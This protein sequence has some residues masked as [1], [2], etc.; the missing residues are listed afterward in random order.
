METNTNL[1]EDT[2]VQE[3]QLPKVES[4][5]KFSRSHIIL[6]LIVGIMLVINIT[7]LAA[8]YSRITSFEQSVNQNLNS[9]TEKV[10]DFEQTLNL[11]KS[12][13]DDNFHR[14]DLLRFDEYVSGGVVT[15]QL[16]VEKAQ[17]LSNDIASIDMTSQPRF[18]LNYEGEGR[19][20]LSDRELKAAILALLAEV[21]SQYRDYF[22]DG[23][24]FYDY[25]IYITQQNY[26]VATYE[27]GELKLTGE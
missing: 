15:N 1:Q 18:S 17:F 21:E 3:E 8:M 26:S 12:D 19:Y 5:S 9:T 23:D 2:S 10:N 4:K 16:I 7:F 24:T 6:T 11:V 25:T 20:E 13:V 27:N 22:Y 14:S